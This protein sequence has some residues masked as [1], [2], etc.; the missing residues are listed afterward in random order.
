MA[1]IIIKTNSKSSRMFTN[2]KNQLK[3]VTSAC[4]SAQYK[5]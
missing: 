2:N 5:P 4:S 3:K 1:N